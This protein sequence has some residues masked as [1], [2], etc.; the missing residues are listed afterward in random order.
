MYLSYE[1]YLEYGGALDEPPLTL[2][3]LE[4]KK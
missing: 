4:Q 1:E 3:N 2:A